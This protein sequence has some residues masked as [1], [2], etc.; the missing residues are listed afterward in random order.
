MGTPFYM[1]PEQARGDRNLDNRVDLYA[2]G[3]MLYECLT[4]RRPFHA[5]NYNALLM[6]ILTTEPRPA[7]EVRP[8]V[9]EGFEQ[10]IARAMARDREKRYQNASEF[11]R[12]VQAL[13]DPGA[14]RRM[15]SVPPEPVPLV[16]QRRRE[17]AG[18]GSPPP[19]R[20]PSMRP[21]S[22]NLDNANLLDSGAVAADSGSLEIPIVAEAPVSA[23][24]LYRPDPVLEAQAR[25]KSIPPS[26]Q[27]KPKLAAPPP[28]PPRKEVQ[29]PPAFPRPRTKAPTPTAFEQR[30]LDAP[31]LDEGHDD[32]DPTEIGS[33]YT[34]GKPHHE[35]PIDADSTERI[36]PERLA[37]LGQFLPRGTTPE[38]SSRS[39]EVTPNGERLATDRF[40]AQHLNVSDDEAPTTLFDRASLKAQSKKSKSGP[41][42][43]VRHT[44]ER[45]PAPPTRQPPTPPPIPRLRGPKDR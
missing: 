7:R 20:P 15:P 36:P 4:G 34:H 35:P 24:A 12:D 27:P 44:T 43:P 39:S 31:W 13:R 22:V 19:P 17:D 9:P 3:V 26:S 29:Q 33:I 11:Q 41:N 6:Q 8:A 38:R 23:R 21:V 18:R 28:I 1:S 14:M 40:E 25:A 10:V 2:T 45:A 42:R 5:S 16:T 30:G 32:A 37:R